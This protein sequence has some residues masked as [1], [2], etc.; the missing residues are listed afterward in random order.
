ML[1]KFLTDNSPSYKLYRTIVQGI[2]GALIA[3][4]PDIFGY[5]TVFPDYFKPLIIALVMAVLA[6][7]MALLGK[8]EEN[9]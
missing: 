7:I 2:I 3:Y 4:L 1:N 8:D 9:E 5:V 6:P